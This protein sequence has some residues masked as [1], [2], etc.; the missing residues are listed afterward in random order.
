MVRWLAAPYQLRLNSVQAAHICP[1]ALPCGDPPP[2]LLVY[3]GCVCQTGVDVD[4][5][6]LTGLVD[7]AVAHSQATNGGKGARVI[8]K[9]VAKANELS[10]RQDSSAR[11]SQLF[12]NLV[13]AVRAH[14]KR[15]VRGKVK[16][17]AKKRTS[18]KFNPK[19]WD[20][21]DRG[22]GLSDKRRKQLETTM[23]CTEKHPIVVLST[24]QSTAVHHC[25]LCPYAHL[26]HFRW[27]MV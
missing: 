8:R 14:D 9:F 22:C 25:P 23:G 17:I 4:D 26:S 15:S 18:W 27:E 13:K 24:C 3:K 21:L 19:V 16:A 5:L 11:L 6:A 12:R 7:E 20:P 1:H 10:R 2:V